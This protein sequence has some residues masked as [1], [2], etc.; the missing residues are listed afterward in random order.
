MFRCKQAFIE[1]RKN[2]VQF[3]PQV[4]KKGRYSFFHK[5]IKKDNIPLF[6]PLLSISGR[7]IQRKSAIK[8]LGVILDENL[9][10]R[11]HITTFETKLV[12][13]KNKILFKKQDNI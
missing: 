6:L 5:S 9:T 1:P 10:W 13:L 12:Y 11:A 7:L 3:F 8:I 2:K 4:N